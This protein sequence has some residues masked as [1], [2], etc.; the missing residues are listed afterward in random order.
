M[1]INVGDRLYLVPVLATAPT[2]AYRQPECLVISV[3]GK[4]AEVELPDG[5]RLWTFAANLRRR[6]IEDEPATPHRPTGP[7]FLLAPGEEQPTL[8]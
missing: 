3:Q 2:A 5:H 1:S 6:P 8:W 7:V 4:R